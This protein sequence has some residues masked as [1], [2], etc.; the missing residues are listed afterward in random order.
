MSSN[1]SS[2][3][4]VKKRSIL[5]QEVKEAVKLSH[6][7]GYGEQVE[8]SIHATLKSIDDWRVFLSVEKSWG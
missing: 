7:M 4:W 1:T 6:Q 5:S 2:Y 3:G 8:Q